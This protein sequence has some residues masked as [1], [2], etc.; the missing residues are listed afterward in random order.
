MKY[1][2]SLSLLIV[3]SPFFLFGQP[4]PKDAI[5]NLDSLGVLAY[6]QEDYG[7]AT[8][9]WEQMKATIEQNGLEKD[10]LG[11]LQYVATLYLETEKYILAE[12]LYLKIS[13][14]QKEQK[15]IDN[16]FYIQ[17][18]GQLGYCYYGMGRYEMAEQYY[19]KALKIARSILENT[20]PTY[21]SLLNN[22]GLLYNTTGRYEEA[23]QL[24]LEV[25]E[26][27][28]KSNSAHYYATSLNNLAVLYQ[29]MEHYEAAKKLYLQSQE[30]RE[31]IYGVNHVNY[32]L[33][34]NNIGNLYEAMNQDFVAEEYYK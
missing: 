19:L 10:Y 21:S 26:I 6:Y 23:E 25:V 4:S 20:A 14:L 32:A 24:Y 15:G 18:V 34:L 22:L 28:R 17:C 33:G 9:F 7:Q 5:A 16:V 12:T 11:A 8:Y 3:C 29:E 30:L 2:L 31:D 13:K 1:F 27:D